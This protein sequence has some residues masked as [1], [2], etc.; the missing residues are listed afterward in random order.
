MSVTL[1]KNYY[2]TLDLGSKLI[3][4]TSDTLKLAF[5]DTA[6]TT[7]THVYT[8]I[9]S[10]LALTNMATCFDFSNVDT[11]HGN[12]DTWC[13]NVDR[14]FSDRKLRSISIYR[15]LR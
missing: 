2:L 15:Y 6:P 14:N 5:T 8:D 1:S 12:S 7:A 10:P 11:I 4:F 3:N 13:G 9:V